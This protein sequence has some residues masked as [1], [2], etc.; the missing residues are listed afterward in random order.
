MIAEIGANAE[1]RNVH[2]ESK[3]GLIKV[4]SIGGE[5]TIVAEGNSTD[6]TGSVLGEIQTFPE[7]AVTAPKREETADPVMVQD[8]S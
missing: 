3:S 7:T 1:T 8:I 6:M 5:V 4:M 2:V